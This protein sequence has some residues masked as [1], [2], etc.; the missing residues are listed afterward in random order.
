NTAKVTGSAFKDPSPHRRLQLISASNCNQLGDDF[1]PLLKQSPDLRSLSINN[2]RLTDE[3][4]LALK[5]HPELQTLKLGGTGQWTTKGWQQ[6][7]EVPHLWKLEL[8]T[9]R[10]ADESLE[11]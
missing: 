1:L 9:V 10:L 6:L 4:F 7:G 11:H 5:D 3:L 8:N 2:S